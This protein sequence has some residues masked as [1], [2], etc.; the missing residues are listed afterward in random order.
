MS[1]GVNLLLLL[2]PVIRLTSR[3]N[4]VLHKLPAL[5]ACVSDVLNLLQLIFRGKNGRFLVMVNDFCRLTRVVFTQTCTKYHVLHEGNLNF[6]CRYLRPSP[7]ARLAN[8]PKPLSPFADGNPLLFARL[9]ATP[10]V[11][12]D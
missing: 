5:L 10:A 12:P 6:G 9:D 4:N 11:A 1:V 2:L 8:V 3:C 7:L